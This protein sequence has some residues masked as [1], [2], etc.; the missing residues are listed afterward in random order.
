[1]S[2]FDLS[3]TLTAVFLDENCNFLASAR[4]L[5]DETLCV[6]VTCVE[7]HSKIDEIEVHDPDCGYE[8]ELLKDALTG[9]LMLVTKGIGY[10][11]SVSDEYKLI[12]V[13][14]VEFDSSFASFTAYN[15][16]MLYTFAIMNGK[17]PVIRRLN[18]KTN[19][20]ELLYT[21]LSNGDSRIEN[22]FVHGDLAF[23]FGQHLYFEILRPNIKRKAFYYEDVNSLLPNYL[24]DLYYKEKNCYM[25][26]FLHN[27]TVLSY[28]IVDRLTFQTRY[29]STE[30]KF[31]EQN[32][33]FGSHRLVG[34]RNTIFVVSDFDTD[35]DII[36]L[37]QRN[38]NMDDLIVTGICGTSV[39][40]NRRDTNVPDLIVFDYSDSTG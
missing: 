37:E 16:E 11:F 2:Y 27:R 15:N 38:V 5:R 36:V 6:Q 39:L 8:V 12:L 24:S 17:M 18:S 9:D 33:V 4:R 22:F 30:M 35:K 19:E 40:F 23:V 3:N 26:P 28:I 14:N 21:Y 1:M 34:F 29:I 10:E 32:I 7:D 25:I 20:N 13:R 31:S